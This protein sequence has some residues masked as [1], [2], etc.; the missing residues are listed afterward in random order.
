MFSSF[1]V[2]LLL[3]WYNSVSERKFARVAEWQ[4]RWFKVPVSER[5]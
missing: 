4:T 2:I 1:N 3:L 5:T